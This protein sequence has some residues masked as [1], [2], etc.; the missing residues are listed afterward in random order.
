MTDETPPP[1]RP[2]HLRLLEG[3]KRL[4]ELIGALTVIGGA[5]GSIFYV[6]SDYRRSCDAQGYGTYVCIG[7]SLGLVDGAKLA[8]KDALIQALRQRVEELEG[9]KAIIASHEGSSPELER[10][11]ATTETALKAAR[12]DLKQRDQR[13]GVLEGRIETLQQRLISIRGTGGSTSSASSSASSSK[14]GSG[15][16]D[17]NAASTSIWPSGTISAGDTRTAETPWGKLS[18]TGGN[19][20]TGAPRHCV[21]Q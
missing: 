5:A 10:R 2:A 9:T 14:P 19:N 16:P 8:A 3:V 18:C 21:W 15:R 17:P 13:I 20:N 12:D 6:V 4:A 7:S 1:G 11:L